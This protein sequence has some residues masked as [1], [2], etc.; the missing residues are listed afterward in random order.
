MNMRAARRWSPAS[1]ITAGVC[2]IALAVTS[3]G[4]ASARPEL[5]TTSSLEGSSCSHPYR[6][7][8][9]LRGFYHPI[10]HNNTSGKDPAEPGL[11]VSGN[12]IGTS[13]EITFVH[14]LPDE[15]VPIS[16]IPITGVEFTINWWP[17]T[18]RSSKI[19]TVKITFHGLRTFI[20]HRTGGHDFVFHHIYTDRPLRLE[21]TAARWVG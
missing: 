1:A 5:S 19:C 2:L 4:S 7:V 15:S 6:L 11:I 9:D 16:Q 3:G 14:Y 20:S 17:I 12:H 8:K 10:R 21:I 18:V 13:M